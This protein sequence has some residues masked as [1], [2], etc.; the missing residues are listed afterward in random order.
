MTDEQIPGKKEVM[1][2]L[3]AL[4]DYFFA[5]ANEITYKFETENGWG[6]IVTAKV[7]QRPKEGKE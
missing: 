5:G 6:L 7:I 1:S 2:L 4:G 3:A